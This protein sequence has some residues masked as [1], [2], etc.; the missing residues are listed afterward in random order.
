MASRFGKMPTASVRRL[1]SL[2]RRSGL[3]DQICRQTAGEGGEGQD[4]VA[5][6]V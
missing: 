5:G 1:I 6:L 2:F 4:V 3:L